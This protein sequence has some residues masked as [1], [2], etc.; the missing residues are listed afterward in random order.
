MHIP[1][2]MDDSEPDL[3]GGLGGHSGDQ[4]PHPMDDSDHLKAKYWPNIRMEYVECPKFFTEDQ[5]DE[6]LKGVRDDLEDALGLLSYI[7]NHSER[8]PTGVSQQIR[9]LIT[10]DAK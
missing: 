7:Y 5:V 2:S 6:L 9:E 4:E 1:Y 10:R 8:L 3:Y